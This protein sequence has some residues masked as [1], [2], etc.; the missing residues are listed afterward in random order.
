M[1]NIM[2]MMKDLSKMEGM[3]GLMKQLKGGKSKR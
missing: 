1:G 2:N 3:E